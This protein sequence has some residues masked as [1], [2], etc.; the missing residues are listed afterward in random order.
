ML[1][2][3]ATY[4]AESLRSVVTN[5]AAGDPFAGACRPVV[6][7]AYGPTDL[8]GEPIIN[9]QLFHTGIDLAC[10]AGVPIHS[11]TDG[12]VHVFSTAQSG[13]FGNEVVV[14]LSTRLPGDMVAQSYFIRYAHLETV[15][16]ADGTGVHAGEVVGLEGSTGFSTGPHLHFEIDRGALDV[17]DSTDPTPLLRFGATG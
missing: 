10:D 17:R 12:V 15:G 16:V 11:V 9:G 2:W 7:Q 4:A 6:T 13:G 14:E 1:S 8:V 3:A 5:A